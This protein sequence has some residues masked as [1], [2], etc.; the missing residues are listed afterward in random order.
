MSSR[1]R[2]RA[3]IAAGV[4]VAVGALVV[5]G[6]TA[7]TASAD[8]LKDTEIV[9]GQLTVPGNSRAGLTVYCPS[10]KRPTGGG[11]YMRQGLV[12]VVVVDESRP[13][14]NGWRVRA[15]NL[16]SVAQN[17]DVSVVCSAGPVPTYATATTTTVPALQTRNVIAPCPGGYVPVGGGYRV[18]GPATGAER[19]AVIES[20]F[21]SISVDPRQDGWKIRVRNTTASS[22]TVDAWAVCMPDFHQ[23]DFIRFGW[24]PYEVSVA[25]GTSHRQIGSATHRTMTHAGYRY[26]SP[27]LYLYGFRPI[28]P[29][30]WALEAYV[31]SAA[32]QPATVQFNL[33]GVNDFTWP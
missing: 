33:F 29:N 3:G 15:R 11:Y 20:D 5:T 23:N 31:Y 13:S 30:Q 32:Q 2:R 19:V 22:R 26:S 10:G 16:G 24:T 17:V 28:G 18:E 1:R 14:G 21:T 7:T 6:L 4:F 12:T 8:R 25:P 27:H 9:S